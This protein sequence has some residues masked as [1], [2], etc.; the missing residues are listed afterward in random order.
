M[1]TLNRLAAE[2]MIAAGGTACTDVTG[3]GLVGHARN[4]AA[5]SGVTIRIETSAVPCFDGVLELA[6]RGFLSGAAQR[7]LDQLKGEAEIGGGLDE[8]IVQLV[9]D[10]ETSGGLLISIP[11]ERAARLEEELAA[12]DQLVRRIG[13]VLPPAGVAIQVV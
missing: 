13:T 5:A 7:G 2:A 9:F 3:F 12:R 6:E 10:A 8:T 11:E 4:V 1:A